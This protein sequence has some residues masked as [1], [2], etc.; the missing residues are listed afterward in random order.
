MQFTLIDRI[1]DLKPGKSI[2]AVKVL[3][4][5]EEYLKDHFPRFP[6]MPGVLM[7]ESMFQASAFLVYKS[8]DFRHS[9]V[10][11]KQARNVRY[12]DFVEPGNSLII[13]AE[14]QKQDDVT[15]TVKAQATTDGK[16]AVSG[17]LVLERFNLLDRYP[18][19]YVEG[20]DIY[21]SR[22]MKQRF[23]LL[24]AAGSSS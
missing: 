18:D 6:V 5:A 20:S 16:V 12:A 14:I 9:T 8:E 21:T 4:L 11:L 15:T 10:M 1:T 19:T 13:S 24:L 17:R 7:L 22:K 3:A 2:Q 23:D